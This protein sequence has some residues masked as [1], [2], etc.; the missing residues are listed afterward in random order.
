MVTACAI[1]PWQEHLAVQWKSG[2]PGFSQ[3]GD[4]Q[5]ESFYTLEAFV[6]HE[7]KDEVDTDSFSILFELFHSEEGTEDMQS[8]QVT[9]WGDA[10]EFL[11]LLQRLLLA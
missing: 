4:I 6:C 11:S 10:S 3:P 8:R 7:D 5:T 2:I 1:A 9:Q